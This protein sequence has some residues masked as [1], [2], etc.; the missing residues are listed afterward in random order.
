MTALTVELE[1]Q[2]PADVEAAERRRIARLIG[3]GSASF[4]LVIALVALVLAIA[5]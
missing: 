5:V 3:L 2:A 1:L 4:T